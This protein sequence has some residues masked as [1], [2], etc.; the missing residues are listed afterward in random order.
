[1][2]AYDYRCVEC[3]HLFSGISTIAKR[4]D[5]VCPKCGGETYISLGRVNQ[6]IQPDM[7]PYFDKGLGEWV[8]GRQ[9]RKRKMRVLGLSEGGGGSIDQQALDNLAE[10]RESK[11][12][13]R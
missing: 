10:A 8:T 4:R 3:D 1:M 5:A 2:P 9:D 7:K 6:G 11:Y 12:A 13:N